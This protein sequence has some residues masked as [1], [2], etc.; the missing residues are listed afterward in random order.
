MLEGLK[1]RPEGG[2]SG[3]AQDLAKRRRTE[4]DFMNGYVAERGTA[5]GVPAPTHAAIAALVRRIE[6]GVLEPARDLLKL[7]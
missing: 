3:T 6:R 1:R 4:V 2:R 7:L 5:C